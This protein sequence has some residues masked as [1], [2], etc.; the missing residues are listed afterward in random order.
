MNLFEST[1][2]NGIIETKEKPLRKESE[3]VKRSTDVF[4]LPFFFFFPLYL[5]P[6][7]ARDILFGFRKPLGW[8]SHCSVSAKTITN[9]VRFFHLVRLS[10][11]GPLVSGPCLYHFIMFLGLTKQ[12]LCFHCNHFIGKRRP[13]AA[14]TCMVVGAGAEAGSGG[15]EHILHQV[16]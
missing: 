5:Q 14:V 10:K 3:E 1:A 4:F 11:H 12:A 15:E 7:G 2:R 9:L 8:I 13:A 16:R 6:N